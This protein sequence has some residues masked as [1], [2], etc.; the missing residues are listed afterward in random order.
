M[1]KRGTV[2]QPLSTLTQYDMSYDA[3]LADLISRIESIAG[4]IP[5]SEWGAIKIDWNEGNEYESGSIDFVYHRL[6]TDDEMSAR[7]AKSEKARVAAAATRRANSA[8]KLAAEKEL[9]QKLKAKY[10][11]AP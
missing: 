3:S 2:S 8:K 9:F 11:S 7:L 1:L 10:E 4:D 6:E 5:R